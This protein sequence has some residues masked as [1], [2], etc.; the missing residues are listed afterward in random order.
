MK[1]YKYITETIGNTPLVKINRLPG[2]NSAEVY[3]KMEFFNPSSSIK[4]RI[5]ISMVEEAVKAGKLRSGGTIIEP[6]SGNTGL[7]LAMVAA[8]NGYKLVIA[9]PENMSLERRRMLEHMGA[10]IV[11]T[12]AAEGMAGAVYKAKELLEAIPGAFMP[13]QFENP[14][15]PAIHEKTTGPEIWKDT[16]G[17]V[18]IFVAGVGTGG[19]LTG[20]GRFLKDKRASIKIVA[21]EPET[22]AVLSGSKA[23][24]HGIQGIGAGFVP[25]VM[26]T[27]LLD[28]IIRVSDNDSIETARKLAKQEGVMCGISS[29]ANVFAALE[30]AKRPENRGK[31]IVTIVCDTAE[32]YLSTGLFA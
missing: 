10:E 27:G 32:R 7:G 29:G 24:K 17:K 22:S 14:S 30:L 13:Q 18:D 25:S 15:N 26:E 16:G 23:G 12:K 11:L 20:V 2:S 6:T 5:A 9:M 4:D 1:L 21:V 8:A 19:T 31:T 3:G 28:E